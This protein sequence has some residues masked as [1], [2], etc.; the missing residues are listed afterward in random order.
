MVYDEM[1]Q[2]IAEQYLCFPAMLEMVIYNTTGKSISQYNI[3]ER[4][5]ITVPFNYSGALKNIIKSNDSSQYGTHI[6]EKDINAFL[7]ETGIP[8]KCEYIEGK[9]INDIFFSERIEKFLSQDMT[10]ICSYSYG[11]LYGVKGAISLGHIS[12]VLSIDNNET[13]QIYDPGPDRHGVKSVSS[14][15]LHDAIRYRNGGLYLFTRREL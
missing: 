3:A 6:E 2:V 11:Y 1:K 13:V 4:F 12:Q 8:L 7:T 14:I 15:L 5:G 10:I 9:R